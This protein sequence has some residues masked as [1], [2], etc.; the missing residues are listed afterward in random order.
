MIGMLLRRKNGTSL[1]E[2][3][4]PVKKDSVSLPT[5]QRLRQFLFILKRVSRATQHQ[6]IS[7]LPENIRDTLNGITEDRIAKRRYHAAND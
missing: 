4:V 1:R 3:K 2:C 7:A 6:L 5:N